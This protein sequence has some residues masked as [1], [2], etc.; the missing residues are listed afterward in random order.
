MQAKKFLIA[1]LLVAVCGLAH[2]QDKVYTRDGNVI[3][4]KIKSVY[5]DNVTYL[6]NDNLTGPDYVIAKDDVEKIVYNNGMTEV[7]NTSRFRMPHPPMHHRHHSARA[8]S[9]RAGMQ[10]LLSIAPL[11]FTENG[12]GFA[13]SYERNIDKNGIVAFYVPVIATFSTNDHYDYNTGQDIP[14]GQNYM[15]YAMPGI[16]IYPTG[17]FGVVKYALGPSLVVATGQKATDIYDPNVGYTQT[18]S[19]THT[20]LGV[21]INNSLNINPGTHLHL[22]LEFG[23]GFTY[24]NVLGGVNQ[25]TTGFVQGSFSIGYR[26]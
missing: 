17:S 12:L 10:N 8:D 7:F 23:F 2:A 21:V 13:V 20:M 19:E 26:F 6:R 4:A 5:L 15:L 18:R 1:M 16:K 24:L 3:A 11:Q 25:N 22:G 9:A 14:A